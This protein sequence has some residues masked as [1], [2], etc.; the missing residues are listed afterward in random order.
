MRGYLGNPFGGVQCKEAVTVM[1]ERR[2]GE[3][4]VGG[5]QQEKKKKQ[6]QIGLKSSSN[7]RISL[8]RDGQKD[9][10]QD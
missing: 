6:H 8:Q 10:T 2:G 1:Q 3:R 7:C 4:V 5:E 9:D